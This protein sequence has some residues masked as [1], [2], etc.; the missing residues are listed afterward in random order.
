MLYCQDQELDFSQEETAIF[1]RG[2]SSISDDTLDLFIPLADATLSDD[3]YVYSRITLSNINYKEE[4]GESVTTENLYV[5]VND[6]IRRGFLLPDPAPGGFTSLKKDW[7][8]SYGVNNF[9][10]KLASLFRKSSILLEN[11][12]EHA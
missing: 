8:I 12:E 6:L 4:I 2:V 5:S 7:A 1:V 9:T 3:N 10:Y 11:Y